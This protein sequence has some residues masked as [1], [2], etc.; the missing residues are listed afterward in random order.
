[1]TRILQR[2]ALIAAAVIIP[3][4]SA[5]AQDAA[6][7]YQQVVSANPF[8]LLLDVFNGEYERVISESS[9]AGIGGSSLNSDD[10]KYLNADVFF[11]YYPRGV[12]LDGWSFGAKAGVTNIPDVATRFGYG[13]DVNRSWLMGKNENFYV[14]VG[15]GLKRL[16]GGGGDEVD[17]QTG[18]TRFDPKY[19]PTFRLVN[20]GFAF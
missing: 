12:P 13:F 16:V 15:F 8:G 17:E 19:I 6:P 3:T 18:E 2:A 9:T 7:R 20:I 11:R 5:Q 1:M 14:G 10:D 4:A